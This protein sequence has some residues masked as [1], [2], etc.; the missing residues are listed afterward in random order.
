MSSNVIPF[1]RPKAKKLGLG[2]HGHH[3]WEIVKDNHFDSKQGKL[4]TVYKC[5]NCGKQKVKSH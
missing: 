5:T 4:V 1:K 2:Q 3:K